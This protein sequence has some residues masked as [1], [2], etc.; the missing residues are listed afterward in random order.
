MKKTLFLVVLLIFSISGYPQV[1]INTKN[2]IG[3]LHIDGLGNNLAGTPTALELDDDIV[4]KNDGNG[5]INVSLGGNV[6]NGASIALRSSNKGFMPNRVALQS[7]VDNMTISPL[8]EGTIVYNTNT[9]ND[10][11]VTT[12]VNSGYYMYHDG[13]WRRL[14]TSWAT[15]STSKI[16][17]T[18]SL[19]TTTTPTSLNFGKFTI[20]D[21]GFYVF[22]LNLAGTAPSVSGQ[23][24]VRR[25]AFKLLLYRKGINDMAFI[26][27]DEMDISTAVFTSGSSFTYNTFLTGFCN[28]GDEIE[29][30]IRNGSATPQCTFNNN[31]FLTLWRTQ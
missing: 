27:I 30:R 20:S 26:A 5:G 29:I 25:G 6:I 19:T 10:N 17:L 12:N 22:S 14:M 4:I 8:V 21:T 3:E 28:I 16:N 15:T 24:T 2:P 1:G 9:T 23:G 31:T 18:A 13:E 11:V 7:T